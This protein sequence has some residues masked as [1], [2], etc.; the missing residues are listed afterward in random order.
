MLNHGRACLALS[1]VPLPSSSSRQKA[2]RFQKSLREVLYCEIAAWVRA[3][4]LR[5]VRAPVSMKVAWLRMAYPVV[6]CHV[7]TFVSGA[8]PGPGYA[9]PWITCGLRCVTD[10]ERRA[11]A[12]PA[13]KLDTASPLVF[14]RDETHSLYPHS[15]P[16]I[17]NDSAKNSAPRGAVPSHSLGSAHGRR[18]VHSRL[19]HMACRV[20]CLFRHASTFTW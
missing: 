2:G 9:G 7:R 8:A 17:L 20:T 10:L 12:G 18:R 1:C 16:F 4:S 19:W 14:R 13:G 11:A 3:G 5:F 6:V 15:R